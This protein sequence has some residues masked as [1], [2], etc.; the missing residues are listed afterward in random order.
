MI[1]DPLASLKVVHI[2]RTKIRTA[3]QGTVKD[4]FVVL[5]WRKF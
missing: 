3:L 5:F 4:S 2:M 1:V